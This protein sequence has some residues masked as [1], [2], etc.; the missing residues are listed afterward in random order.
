MPTIAGHEYRFNRCILGSED[1]PCGRLRHDVNSLAREAISRGVTLVDQEGVAHFG[2]LTRTEW[3]QIVEDIA[4]E[5]K[6]YD[7]AMSSL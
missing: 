1:N 3:D 7:M 6:A 5:D 2:R 4:A